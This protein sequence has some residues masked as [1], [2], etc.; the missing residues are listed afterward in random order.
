[1]ARAAGCAD[2]DTLLTRFLPHVIEI[3]AQPRVCGPVLAQKLARDIA[4]DAELLR[5]PVLALTVDRTE[6]RDLRQPPLA[7]V[8]RL[9]RNLEHGRLRRGV[10]VLPSLERFE[11]RGVATEVRCDAQ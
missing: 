9:D 1:C 8:D 2:D 6:V 3:L 4:R 10:N 7:G 11:Q 5:Q